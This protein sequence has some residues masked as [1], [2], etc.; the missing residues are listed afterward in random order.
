MARYLE[1]GPF[2]LDRTEHV[3]V[4]NGKPVPIT[5]KAFAT[6]EALVERRGHILGR[7]ELM[8]IV[9][10]E[11]V[12]EENNLAQSICLLRKILGAGQGT[13]HFI[14]TVPKRGYRFVARVTEWE[15]RSPGPES[16][17]AEAQLPQRAAESE[18]EAQPAAA[19]R[20]QAPVA[21]RGRKI[22]GT[23]QIAALAA[24]VVLVAVGLAIHRRGS[25]RAG[26]GRIRSLAVLPLENLSHD[27]N[28]DYL[29]DGMTDELI[30]DLAEIHALRVVSR[31]SVMR[32]RNT[33]EPLP[34]IAHELNVDAVVE[35]A[36]FSSGNRVRITAQLVQASSDRHLWARSYEANLDDALTLQ[37]TVA[38]EIAEAIQIKLTPNERLH[39]ANPRVV[40]PA[41]HSD[42]LLG[43]YFLN[44]RTQP[45]IEKSIAYFNR[46]AA[47]EP[48][49]APAYAGLADAYLLLGFYGVE[50]QKVM[51][52]AEAAAHKALSLDDSLPD[53]YAALGAVEAIYGWDWARAGREFRRAI[54]LNPN[55]AP[56]YHWYAVLDLVP[57]GRF[58]E[59]LE[60]M[61]KAQAL[62]PA[63]PL[64]NTDLGWI[65]FIA[66]DDQ[67]ALEQFHQA[68]QLDPNFLEALD[69][70]TQFYFVRGPRDKAL[71]EWEKAGTVVGQTQL[72]AAVKSAYETSGYPAALREIARRT[73][74]GY[75][76][77]MYCA[78]A[79]EK[80]RA[81]VALNLAYALRDPGLIYV[82][83]DPTLASLHSDPRF[84]KLTRGMGL[85]R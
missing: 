36:V 59:A 32:Y 81:F 5:P 29:A 28:Q 9:W 23:K 15:E 34:Q 40:D 77:A 72:I 41:A 8:K 55:Y 83:V 82:K 19:V 58:D 74:L 2:T 21:P 27:P 47:R 64:M 42:Y 57:Q 6:L 20:R 38:R 71:A 50:P 46:A 54:T 52:K 30:T 1:F 26:A 35:G 69:R 51:P 22:L 80:A 37:D 18:A 31:T 17:A 39:L 79:G 73:R 25:A 48:G 65:Y 13:S 56:A 33:N 68:L 12:V 11:V 61:K 67:R 3:L 14:E 16:K 63:S 60:Q 78:L 76:G 44:R 85:A 75:M 43:L 66:G 49:Y 7:D 53:A 62:D 70:L 45:S 24:V 84:K 4:S 10:P